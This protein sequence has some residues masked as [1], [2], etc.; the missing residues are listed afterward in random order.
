MSDSARPHRQQL[1]RLCHPWDSPGKNSGVGCHCL[2][3]RL[4]TT[5]ELDPIEYLSVCVC[6]VT[7]WWL[8]CEPMDC[9]LPGSSVHGILQ[10]RLLEWVAVPVSRGSSQPRNRT[11]VSHIAGGSFTVWATK[12]AQEYWREEAYPSSR[13]SSRN[14]TEVSCIAGILYLLN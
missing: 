4:Y 3:P 8:F 2:L 14:W 10:A 9:S 5:T 13:G 11:Q 12:E 1:T 6:L 7:Q